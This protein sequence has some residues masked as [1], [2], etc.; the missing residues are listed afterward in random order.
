METNGRREGGRHV[1]WENYAYWPT[2]RQVR[3]VQQMF[4]KKTKLSKWNLEHIF[5]KY[6]RPFHTLLIKVVN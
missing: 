6:V 3:N 2:S 5:Y 4:F 1:H